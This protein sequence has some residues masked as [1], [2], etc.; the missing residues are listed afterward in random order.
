MQ[1]P[2]ADANRRNLPAAALA[3]ILTVLLSTVGLAGAQTDPASGDPEQPKPERAP[4]SVEPA[5]PGGRDFFVYTLS[6]GETF[7]D[8]VAVSNLGDRPIN[9]SIFAKDAFSVPNQGGFAAGRDEDEPADVGSWISLKANSYLAEP[10][11]RAEIP[12]SITVPDDAEPGDHAGGILV[13]DADLAEIDFSDPGVNLQTRERVGARVY[14]RVEGPIT[15]AL[16]IDSIVVDHDTPAI[17]IPFV[18]NSGTARVDWEITNSGN[19]RLT[20]TAVL[21]V[22]GLFG[23]TVAT[24][25]PVEIPELLP[26]G[27]FIQTQL[28]DGLPV[29][30][31]LTVEL[32]VTSDEADIT[33]TTS[34]WAVAWVVPVIVLLVLLALLLVRW[35]RRR[36]NRP[37]QGEPPPKSR[38]SE[39]VDA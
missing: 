4:F 2:P 3:A 10:G 25:P 26:D 36:R 14:V 5:G 32:E 35:L 22:K 38:K 17:G 6:P 24:L 16:T 29:F 37:P 7:G 9:F 33:G 21:K 18:S 23:R 31:R 1:R 8:S 39:L 30:E 11:T 27:N 13:A 15:P 12:F 20:P 19:T 28:L 34:Y